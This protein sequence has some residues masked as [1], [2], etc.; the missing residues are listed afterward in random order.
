VPITPVA[1]VLTAAFTGLNVVGV[2]KTSRL[3]IALVAVLVVFLV[4]F[5]AVGL[6]HL[7]GQA[8]EVPP[9]VRAA[10]ADRVRG[11]DDHHRHRLRLL[12]RPD[13]GRQ[14]RRGGPSAGPHAPGRDAAGAADRRRR[15]RRRRRESWWR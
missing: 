13:P 12:R 11:A 3:Q 14:R 5:L 7:L 6:T 15:L 10:G 4:L 2:R 1:L 8:G 9:P